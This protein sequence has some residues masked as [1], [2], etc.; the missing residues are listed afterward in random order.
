MIEL[1]KIVSKYAHEKEIKESRQE[2]EEITSIKRGAKRPSF[3]F[4]PDRYN[5][6]KNYEYRHYYQKY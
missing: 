6:K 2:K 3:N 4:H 5:V 1:E